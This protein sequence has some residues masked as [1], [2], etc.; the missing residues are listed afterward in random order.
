MASWT[1]VQGW[2]VFAR[3]SGTGREERIDRLYTTELSQ[4]GSHIAV[5]SRPC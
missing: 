5:R 4:F 1:L 3:Y 2:T